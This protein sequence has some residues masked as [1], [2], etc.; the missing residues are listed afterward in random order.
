MLNLIRKYPLIVAL[1]SLLIT[2]YLQTIFVKETSVIVQPSPPIEN[3]IF[4]VL[5]TLIFFAIIILV[6]RK[7]LFQE[8]PLD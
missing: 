1:I 8:N 3:N 5:Y 4:G 7:L 6:V 2:R